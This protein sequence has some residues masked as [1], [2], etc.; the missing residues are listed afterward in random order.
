M[1]L[2]P[3]FIPRSGADGWQISNPPILSMAPLKASIDLF[4]EA[5]MPALGAKSQRLTACLQFLIDDLNPACG[6]KGGSAFEVITPR[7]AE[8]RGCQI[9]IL[10]HDRPRERFTAL[11][12]GGV[13][14]DFREPN[15]I[16]AA[17]VP[18]YNS[19]HD[20]WRF[21]DALHMAP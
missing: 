15:V 3:D 12:R 14:C 2:L 7:D 19:F 4:D 20:V 11:E 10:V 16:R 5:T 18:L 9:S 6:R 8:S 21:A 13:V 1:H 17:P